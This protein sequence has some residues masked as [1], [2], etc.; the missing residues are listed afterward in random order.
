M[1]IFKAS[2]RSDSDDLD[3]LRLRLGSE[4]YVASDGIAAREEP[5]GD[6]LAD[7]WI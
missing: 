7:S 4:L 5:L 2:I 1:R 6:R 3:V